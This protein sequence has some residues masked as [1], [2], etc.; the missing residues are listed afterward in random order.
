MTEMNVRPLENLRYYLM[1]SADIPKQFA[2]EHNR[3]F[4]FW[5]SVWDDILKKLNCDSSVLVDDFV[6]QDFIASIF[7]EDRPVAVHLYSF[8]SLNS[9]AATQHRYMQMYPPAFSQKLQ[10]LGVSRVMSMEY[11]TI[12]PDWRKHN[13]GFHLG[14]VLASLAFKVMRQYGADAAIAPARRDHRVHELAYA[15]GGDCIM[16]KVMNHNV[17]CDLIACRAA[18]IT[19]H[20]SPL[21]CEWE[22][23]LWASRTETFN[24]TKR[25]LLLDPANTVTAL[26]AA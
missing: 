1:E 24:Q 7:E 3:V 25:P 2:T 18:K 22:E 5:Y 19:H 13:T 15:Y 10:D 26:P 8:F 20:P 4:S 9:I 12:H 23:K 21:I 6:R 16:E 11:M 14:A 17:L